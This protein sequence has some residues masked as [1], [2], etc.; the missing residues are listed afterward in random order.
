MCRVRTHFFV[1]CTVFCAA[2]AALST[3]LFAQTDSTVTNSD[4]QRALYMFEIEGRYTE[5][6]QL[7]SRISRS[8]DEILASTASLHLAK[9]FELAQKHDSAFHHYE[10]ILSRDLVPLQERR[11]VARHLARVSTKPAKKI[12]AIL[13]K[14]E[15]IRKIISPEQGLFLLQ[16]G[17]AAKLDNFGFRRLVRGVPAQEKYLGYNNGM[18]Y[19]LS[20]DQTIVTIRSVFRGDNPL[21][22][23]FAKPVEHFTLLDNGDYLVFSGKSLTKHNLNNTVWTLSNSMTSC[24]PSGQMQYTQ[25]I[26]LKCPDNTIRLVDHS[27]GEFTQT[28]SILENLIHAVPYADGLVLSAENYVYFFRPSLSLTPIW[29]Q[30]V[31]KIQTVRLLGNSALVQS[32]D[33]HITSLEITTGEINW[34]LFPGRASLHVLGNHF[35]TFSPEGILKYFTPTGE[36]L[37]NYQGLRPTKLAPELVQGLI[38]LPLQNG[39][40]ALLN[41]NYLGERRTYVDLILDKSRLML[42]NKNWVEGKK[43][44]GEV[45]QLE[46]GNLTAWF[47]LG[48]YYTTHAP[49]PDSADFAYFRS[50]LSAKNLLEESEKLQLL[51]RYS[52]RLSADWIQYVDLGNRFF[53][54][55]YQLDNRQFL[56]ID[57]ENQQLLAKELSTG[58]LQWASETGYL[59]G[60]PTASLEYPYL[61]LAGEK[62]LKVF[63]L[64]KK[65]R[66]LAQT[67]LPSA[68]S[69]IQREGDL[70]IISTYDGHIVR[71]DPTTL[72]QLWKIQPF[73]SMSSLVVYKGQTFALARGRM[74]K[75][76]ST[77]GSVVKTRRL[78]QS[79][80]VMDLV[81]CD[82][83]LIASNSG[84]LIQALDTDFNLLWNRVLPMQLFHLKADKSNLYI[85]LSDQSILAVNA[86]DGSRLWQFQGK[87][88]LLM[89]PAVLDNHLVLD[90]GD[91]IIFID[92]SSGLAK[93]KITTPDL[94][95]PPQTFPGQL[96]ISSRNGLLYSFP[97]SLN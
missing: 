4:L 50:T 77:N 55:L 59:G 5:A 66:L 86:L 78:P 81:L 97:L 3:P 53:P 61:A 52:S 30:K 32:N 12:F 83:T 42:K 17:T 33:G 54:K 82:S 73:Q 43:L 35:C 9:L 90:Q 80:N 23:E 26:A 2:L 89:R 20:P 79:T 72:R 24:S 29:K 76:D 8:N 49:N 37:W 60:N 22:V 47:F 36:L 96:L 74:L 19:S 15:E 57:S 87:S 1:V 31:D 71:Y 94:L 58:K 11:Q 21:Q 34:N 85:S 95:G 84:N 28:I 41:P 88:S 75:I 7:L 64:S 25:E 45:L 44:A 63:D 10:A 56:F 38:V 46:P 18:L 69:S 13:E 68:V 70:L 67:D 6:R 27:T 48:E 14:S 39:R 51:K 93:D 65:G 91:E 16:D 92:K 62:Q 40:T